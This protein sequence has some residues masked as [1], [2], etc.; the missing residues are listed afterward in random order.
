MSFKDDLK[1]LLFGAKS[2]TKSAGRKAGEKGREIGEDLSE[3]SKAYYDKAKQ[4]LEDL[5]ETYRPKAKK[6]VDD[7]R[8]FAEEL[9]DEAWKKTDEWRR[10]D[11]TT[12]EP[13]TQ[14]EPPTEAPPKAEHKQ[15]DP[16]FEDIF[17]NKPPETEEPKQYRKTKFDDI[18]EEVFRTADEVSKKAQDVSERVGKRVLDASDKIGQRLSEEGGKLWEKAEHTGGKLKDRFDELVEKANQEAEKESMDELTEEA[19]KMDEEL[20][21][22]VKERG[23]R[24]NAENLARDRKQEP[25][26]GTESFFDKAARYAEGDYS[27]D[28][29]NDFK[30]R[31][32][33]DY[34]PPSREGK[35]KGFQDLD[36]DGDEIID[37]AIID[38]DEEG[39]DK[40]K[41]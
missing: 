40:P 21:R 26:A 20:E 11:D 25:L 36:G 33:P 37:D 15:E 16:S 29:G 39:E 19:K 38:N 34:Q 41:P 35:V 1:K 12:N 7:A 5:D 14:E 28:D 9:V 3:Q 8:S 32:D 6:A 30:I 13:P 4:R 23:Q 17:S 18:G 27:E 10:K 2:V 24:S 22:R 31:Q